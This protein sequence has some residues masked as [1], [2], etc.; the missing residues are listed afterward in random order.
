MS[1]PRRRASASPR[2][3]K[4]T[5]AVGTH[6]RR[7]G[8]RDVWGRR[9]PGRGRRCGSGGL[10]LA[11]CS[12]KTSDAGGSSGTPESGSVRSSR[13]RRQRGKL[14]LGSSTGK[15]AQRRPRLARATRQRPLLLGHAW[16]YLHTLS[17]GRLLV[18]TPRPPAHELLLRQLSYDRRLTRRRSV[19][20]MHG[21]AQRI[22]TTH[23]PAAQPGLRT[24][25][26][27]QPLR[28]VR[29][30]LPRSAEARCAPSAPARGLVAG[31]G[32]GRPN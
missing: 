18:Y 21:M 31:N 15:Q 3:N 8:I 2:R 10:L 28:S 26:P 9:P 13:R 11:G 4:N 24:T 14:V 32:R 7:C 1:S 27:M 30:M 17:G 16:R 29:P 22:S 20:G 6:Q 5:A 23:T 25:R 12:S 19:F